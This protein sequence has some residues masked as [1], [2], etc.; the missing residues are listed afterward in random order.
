MHMFTHIF[1]HMSMHMRTHMSMHMPTHMPMHISMRISM[2]SDDGR[3]CI[4]YR[5]SHRWATNKAK[6]QHNKK[7]A[8][9]SLGTAPYRCNAAHVYAHVYARTHTHVYTHYTHVRVH[10]L[11][12]HGHTTACLYPC[13]V[14]CCTAQRGVA[15]AV[16]R[17]VLRWLRG[18]LWR[19]LFGAEPTQQWLC[20]SRYNLGLGSEAVARRDCDSKGRRCS[21]LH[22]W[23]AMLWR[24][25]WT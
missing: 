19:P 10:V 21:G 5:L 11:D 17:C 23:F 18:C 16:P 4:G 8:R 9:K 15:Q 2:Y 20:W 1:T 12:P 6:R 22:H 25:F 24:F 3:L 7:I 13:L 14:L